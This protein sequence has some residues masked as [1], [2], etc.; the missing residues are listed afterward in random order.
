MRYEYLVVPAPLRGQKLK[1]AKTPEA[2]FAAAM[3]DIL[4]D[5]ARAGWEYIR[6]D[7]LPS[8][9][10]QGLTGSRTVFVNMLVFRRPVDA[11]RP[12][13][14]ALPVQPVLRP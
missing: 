3:A 12:E 13:P 9:E 2:R 5:Q 10:R 7:V 8:E 1:G 14:A 6:S 4:N 11:A